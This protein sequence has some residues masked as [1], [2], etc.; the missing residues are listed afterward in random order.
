MAQLKVGII[1]CGGRGREHALGYKE[2]ADKVKIVAVADPVLESAQKLAETYGVE[3]IHQDYKEMLANNELDIVSVCTWPEQHREQVVDAV[4]AGVRAIHC[5]KPMAPTWGEARAM[6]QAAE[7]AGVQLTFCHQRRFNPQFVEARRLLQSGAIGDLQRIEG[8][9]PNLFDWGTHWFDMFF[10]L[11]NE[12]PAQW[13]MGQI[14]LTDTRTVFGVPVDAAGLSYTLFENGVAG[15]MVTGKETGINFSVRIIG[16]KGVIDLPH[17]D[18][19]DILLLSNNAQADENGWQT[20]KIENTPR[21][22][23]SIY[24]DS[25]IDSVLEVI[26]CLESG[27]EPLL[28]TRNAV[29]ATELIFATYESARRGGRIHLPLDIEDSPLISMLNERNAASV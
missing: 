25:T 20:I 7:A 16:S 2:A 11:N 22:A 5:E 10:F 29:R 23:G 17:C 26:E 6:H 24:S 8:A 19:G 21:Y 9:C 4:N 18:H 13:V 14:D 27:K 15:L 28:S 1:G 3:N 12:T